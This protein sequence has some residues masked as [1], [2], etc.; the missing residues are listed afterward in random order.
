[1][2]RR[3]DSL[4]FAAIL[5]LAGCAHVRGQITDPRAEPRSPAFFEPLR[6]VAG[7]DPLSGLSGYDGDDLFRLG[8]EAFEGDDFGRAAALF[9]R[10]LEQFPEHPDRC[11]ATWNRALSLEKGGELASAAQGF[12]DYAAAVEDA[13]VVDAARARLR[14]ATILQLAGRFDESA[15]PLARAAEVAGLAQ[16][17]AWEV[18]MLQAMLEASGGS[19]DR[20]ETELER[21]RRDV[22]RASR[23]GGDLFPYQSA[24]V[25]FEAGE[26]YRMRAAAVVIGQVDDLERLDADLGSKAG[27]L[28]EARQHFKRSLAHR[29]ASWSGPAALSLGAVYEDFRRDLLAAPRPS[30][31]DEEAG[32]VYDRV[33]ADRTR[34]FLEKA[35]VDYREVLR[36]AEVLRLEPAWAQAVQDALDR[37]E[38]GLRTGAAA[39]SGPARR[40]G[41]PEEG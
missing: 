24:M 17:E 27:F 20:A 13:D 35:A 3:P 10:M 21:V 8:L 15:I 16:E 30:D 2:T 26:L 38:E 33:L 41:A 39:G 12:E 37:C 9:G 14:A 29:M 22:R 4:A 34:Q 32:A 11:P 40:D 1:M 31:L 7:Q 23:E 25:W 5:L 18:R 19:L 6:I 36:Q 28:M